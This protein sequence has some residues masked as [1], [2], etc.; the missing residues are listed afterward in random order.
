MT[1]SPNGDLIAARIGERIFIRRI[2]DGAALDE[3]SLS[4]SGETPL[5]F[6]PDDRYLAFSD[7]RDAFLRDID[8]RKTIKAGAATK[9]NVA[10]AF[11]PAA[12]KL[13]FATSERAVSFV[14]WQTLKTSQ[15]SVPGHTSYIRSIAFSPDGKMLA[16]GGGIYDGNVMLWSIESGRLLR[17]IRPNDPT[18]VVQMFFSPDGQTLATV[19]AFSNM[20]RLWDVA[21]SRLW[22]TPTRLEESLNAA[23][24][25]FS[26]KGDL[27][28]TLQ[29]GAIVVHD[30]QSANWLESVCRTVNRN[31]TMDEW[32]D[33]V[34][35][36][37]YQA[38]CPELPK[39]R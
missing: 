7:R 5:L 32:K 10:L 6:S 9:N 28:A 19:T 34:G 25:A 27:L 3:I 1:V 8:G 14:D 16:T 12:P 38:P 35:P 4:P 17:I 2:K 24:A 13:A 11:A 39:G 21:S 29:K 22:S 33:Y 26:P 31:L 37:G 20:L 15:L 18:D 23:T 30:L 36:A